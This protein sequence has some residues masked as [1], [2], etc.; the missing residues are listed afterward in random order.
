MAKRVP[1]SAKP[2]K[3]VMTADE[4]INSAPNPEHGNAV[5]PKEA[6]PKK[7]FTIDIPVDLHTRIKSQCAAR[8]SKMNEEVLALLEKHFPA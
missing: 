5:A 1:L 7:R 2:N 8:G 4:W 6:I 3:P